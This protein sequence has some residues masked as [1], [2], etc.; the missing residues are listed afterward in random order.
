MQQ[1]T[2]KQM[3]QELTKTLPLQV[4]ISVLT[5]TILIGLTI[6]KEIGDF[7]ENMGIASEEIFRGQNLP[8]LKTNNSSQKA[9][10]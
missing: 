6:A 10:M 3:N 5:P 2:T 8:V 1:I 9:K 7:M 4:G